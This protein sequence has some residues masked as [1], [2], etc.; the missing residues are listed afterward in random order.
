MTFT[1][2]SGREWASIGACASAHGLSRQVVVYRLSKGLSLKQALQPKGAIKH[3]TTGEQTTW[4]SLSE[5]SGVSIDALLHRYK[6]GAPL[7]SEYRHKPR[8][9]K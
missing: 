8:K 2:P 3:P 7:L 5:E 6:R 1:D 4:R 9:K